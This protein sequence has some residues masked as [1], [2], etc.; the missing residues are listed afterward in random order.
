[1]MKKINLKLLSLTSILTLLPILVGVILWKDLPASLPSHFGLDGQADGFSSKLEVVFLIPLVMLGLHFFAV[2]VTS[3]DPKA[4]HVSPKM[5]TLVYWLVPFI[6]GLVQLSIYG[7]AFGLIGNS[8]RIGLVMVGI[9]FLVV[10]NYLPKTKQ[11][12]TVGIRL[13]WTLDSEENW[14]KTHRLAGRLWVLGGLII[15][16]NGFLSWAVLYVFFGALL[17]MVL[18]PIFYSYWISRSQ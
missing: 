16:V 12:Y 18:V 3:L 7:A 13:P 4:S 14:N 10:G 6:S 11:N 2:V 15:L 17:V 9:V 8:T 1:M 5:K